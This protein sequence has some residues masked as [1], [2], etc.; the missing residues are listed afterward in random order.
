MQERLRNNGLE[1]CRITKHR[2]FL[3]F[4]RRSK[5]VKLDTVGIESVYDGDY[6]YYYD[7]NILC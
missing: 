2:V 3:V 4:V 5:F 6:Y 7:N 1:G